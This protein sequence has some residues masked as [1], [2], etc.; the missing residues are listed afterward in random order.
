MLRFHSHL[1]LSMKWKTQYHM[2]LRWDRSFFFLSI[3]C[4]LPMSPDNTSVYPSMFKL[5]QLQPYACSLLL[6]CLCSTWN[7]MAT[8]T[9]SSYLPLFHLFQLLPWPYLYLCFYVPLCSTC[10]AA[11]LCLLTFLILKCSILSLTGKY[12]RSKCSVVRLGCG[13]DNPNFEFSSKM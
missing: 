9:S 3:P 10:S 11:N 6:I 8:D 5:F 12:A 7:H 4:V 13:M 1:A 2:L